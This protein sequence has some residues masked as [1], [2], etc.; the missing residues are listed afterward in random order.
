MKLKNI[1]SY[2]IEK[3]LM[4]FAK[5]G[6]T[7]QTANVNLTFLNIVLNDAIRR[8]LLDKNPAVDVAPL[9]QNSRV[10]AVPGDG[11]GMAQELCLH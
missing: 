4:V 11:D 3:W 8:K 6:L 9:K 5:R 10:R 1:T 2:D 7:N